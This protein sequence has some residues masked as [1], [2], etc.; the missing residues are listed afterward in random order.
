MRDKSKAEALV[1]DVSEGPIE[2][3]KLTVNSI[4]INDPDS[5]QPA[6]TKLT[7]EIEDPST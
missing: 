1:T 7:G 5:C 6:T 4:A 3:A 2:I